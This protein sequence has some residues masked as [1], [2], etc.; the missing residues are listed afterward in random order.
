MA[1]SK[2]GHVVS[3]TKVKPKDRANK[4]KLVN[5]IHSAIKEFSYLY[6]ISLENQRNS[7]LKD[8]REQL[9]PGRIFF[10]RRKLMHL[11][12]GTRAENEMDTN[13]HH[14]AKILQGERALLCTNS[15]PETILEF[16]ASFRK[17]EFARCGFVA[18]D[19]IVLPEGIEAFQHL[20]HS[21]QPHLNKLGIPIVLKN[22]KLS[23]LQEWILCTN[24]STLTTEQAQLL[25]HLDIRM[26]QFKMQVVAS[27]HQGKL[28]EYV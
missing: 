9:K 8:V 23:M 28:K 5:A 21:L 18:S 27:W 25:K 24:G 10:G 22:G 20:S 11:A 3:L 26:S 7:S 1:K 17:E 19:T 12:L 2:R 14:F 4:E 15:P 6:I 13:L 16:T